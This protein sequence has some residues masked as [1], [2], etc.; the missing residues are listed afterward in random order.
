MAAAIA[1]NSAQHFVLVI[2]APFGSPIVFAVS[3]R[4][5]NDCSKFLLANLNMTAAISVCPCPP[6]RDFVQEDWNRLVRYRRFFLITYVRKGWILRHLMFVGG[7]PLALIESRHVGLHCVESR[8][9]A[10]T[11]NPCSCVP[12]CNNLKECS[13]KE[14]GTRN[15]SKFTTE[16][17]VGSD[18]FGIGIIMC[19]PHT[20][21][22]M[23]VAAAS[24]STQTLLR[25]A[26]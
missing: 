8:M 18:E 10:N 4:A 19:C 15:G 16:M 20:G 17:W 26:E 24:V 3:E 25:M 12:D 5:V 7:G 21:R 6:V 13:G 22:S 11:M 14:V 1:A 2:P 9:V 23:K